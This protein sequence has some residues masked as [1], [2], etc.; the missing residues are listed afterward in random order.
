MKIPYTLPD[1]PITGIDMAKLSRACGEARRE[2]AL[3]SEKT[4]ALPEAELLL[5][6]L[7][8]QEAAA[9]CNLEGMFATMEE[10]YGTGFDPAAT[11]LQKLD[12]GDIHYHRQ[13][14]RYGWYA[15]TYRGFSFDVVKEMHFML[16]SGPRWC[17]KTPGVVRL[18]RN[19]SR[20]AND[21]LGDVFY[22]PPSLE[23]LGG[24]IGSWMD[25]METDAA[26]PLIM[27]GIL[28]AYFWMIR[29]FNVGNGCLGRMCIPLFLRKRGVLDSPYFFLADQ[30][31]A[32][33]KEYNSRLSA[34]F[35][36]AS[37]A[38]WEEWLEFF[39]GAVAA[40]AAESARR[41]EALQGLYRKLGEDTA[42]V[43]RSTHAAALQE[44]VFRKPVFTVPALVAAG[45]GIPPTTLRR[46][47]AALVEAR[48]LT[49]KRA[50]SGSSPAV[51]ALPAIPLAAEGR[52]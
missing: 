28:Y 4:A 33:C 27:A 36:D 26:D 34:L 8:L 52:M 23:K 44:A 25:Y 51:Y 2:L 15:M 3:F 9:S 48:V 14:M 6:P 43:T 13:A 50:A 19:W 5:E 20:T 30:L 37:A 32:R 17:K 11:E 1:L 46:M 47:L 22:A 18:T 38:A 29:P 42:R 7:M 12:V 21:P 49:L 16:L 35:T 45:V 24:Y 31:M 41:A 10:V 40:Q 39:L